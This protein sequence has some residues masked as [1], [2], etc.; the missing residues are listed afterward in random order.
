M[1]NQNSY[2][3]PV[4]YAACLVTL[5]A[6]LMA[7]PPAIAAPVHRVAGPASSDLSQATAGRGE[8]TPQALAEIRRVTARRDGS[9][10]SA[11]STP[12]ALARDAVRCATFEGQRYCLGLGWTTASQ[13]VAQA[14]VARAAT[15]ARALRRSSKTET[16]GDRDALA[17]LRYRA[18]WTPA[19]RARADRRELKAAARS[20]AKIWLLRHQIQGTP[21]PAGFLQAHPEVNNR[22]GGVDASG[23]A[24]DPNAPVKTA[25]DYP[26]MGK[27]LSKKR[28]NDQRV[29]YWCGPATMQMI[30]WRKHVPVRK[31]RYWAKRLHTT[32]SGSD[33]V[34]MVRVVNNKTTWDGPKRA[35]EY[36]VLDIEDFTFGQW[37]NLIRRHIIDYRAPLVLHPV[38]LKEYYPYL[39]DDAS[40]H[41]QVGRGYT[42][43]GDKPTQV[44]FFEPW[45]QQ[46]FD[47]SEPYIDRVQWRNAYKSYRAN[48]EHF[49]HNVGV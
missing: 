30:A 23:N 15:D 11:R 37:T 12:T 41:F 17:K 34:D 18:S 10:L 20:V 2:R 1:L 24:L 35:G 47:P 5:S 38:L 40:G 4:V 13:T 9:T 27:V 16:T 21:L 43:N 49:L 26:E 39:D 32:S 33:I 31:Q 6:T 42:N 36:V 46:R 19:E 14:R 44:G 45:N 8:L 3:R 48:L 28:V 25:K 29:T 22:G 7:T